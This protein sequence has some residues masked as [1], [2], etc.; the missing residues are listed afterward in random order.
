[1]TK[2]KTTDLS[3]FNPNLLN[4]PPG[5]PGHGRKNSVISAGSSSSRLSNSINNV[6]Q[7][8]RNMVLSVKMLSPRNNQQQDCSNPLNDEGSSF[9]DSSCQS[10]VISNIKAFKKQQ[11]FDSI[12]P[13]Q[14]LRLLVDRML[15]LSRNLDLN[16]NHFYNLGTVLG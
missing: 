12:G 4:L 3:D 6:N 13:S 16:I 14:G 9:S 7:Y 11:E 10:E 8:N 1:M 5:T 2:M 15:V